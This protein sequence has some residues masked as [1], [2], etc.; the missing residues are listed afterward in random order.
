MQKDFDICAKNGGRVRIKKLK[1]NKFIKI[2]YDKSGNAFSSDV[3]TE[4]VPDDEKKVK[5]DKQQRQIDDSRRLADS[6][7]ELQKHVNTHY[8]T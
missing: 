6:L 5:A 8:H 7:L 2:C 3:K 4:K 1:N